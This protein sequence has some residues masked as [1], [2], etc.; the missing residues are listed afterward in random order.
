MPADSAKA[1]LP[2]Q[3]PV[4]RWSMVVRA[5][6]GGEVERAEALADLCRAY[7]FPVYSFIRRGGVLPHDAEDLTQG[8]FAMFLRRED[9]GRA[10]PARGRLRTLILTALRHFLHDEWQRAGR[11]KRGGEVVVEMGRDA[12]SRYLQVVDTGLSA[13]AHFDRQWAQQVLGRAMSRLEESLDP[14][15]RRH[16]EVLREA[17]S[18]QGDHG[19][20]DQAAGVL[21]QTAASL[22]VVVHRWRKQLRGFIEAELRDTVASEDEFAA[23]LR[24]FRLALGA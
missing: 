13:D 20:Y 17:L 19:F 3:F 9:F 22:R 15:R 5:V 21:G 18:G 24:D 11:M 23:E 4:T 16:F 10:D 12:E 7:W 6:E 8:F 14:E 2:S 1:Q